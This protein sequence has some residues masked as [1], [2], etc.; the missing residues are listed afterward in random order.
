MIFQLFQEAEKWSSLGWRPYQLHCTPQYALCLLCILRCR[1][2]WVLICASCTVCFS[3]ITSVLASR[4][5]PSSPI[6]PC[7]TV[8]FSSITSVLASRCTPSSPI[9]PCCT[10]CFSSITSVLASRCTP[11]SP[12]SPCCT[13]CFSS[14]TSV[15]ASR[16]TPSSPI[17]PCLGMLAQFSLNNVH[18]R[19]LKHHLFSFFT[20]HIGTLEVPLNIVE[21][22]K[23]M[24]DSIILHTVIPRDISVLSPP[25]ISCWT[26]PVY[27]L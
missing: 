25:N 4:C 14:I 3:S 21:M 5:T 27:Y 15:L 16:C 22:K 23:I 17:S 7:C 1:T 13:V 20:R 18:K 2:W 26:L 6:S 9:S 12:I 11:S 10:V 19:G 24:L 8:C